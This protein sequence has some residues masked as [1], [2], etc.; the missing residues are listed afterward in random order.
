MII[1]LVIFILIVISIVI[2]ID[3]KSKEKEKELGLKK[4][5]DLKQAI[6]QE[7]TFKRSDNKPISD[8][9][10]PGLIKLGYQQALEREKQS[11]NIKFHRTERDEELSFQ[12]ESNH[13]DEIDKHVKSFE[14]CYNL[15]C[16][17][18]DLN[19][20]IELLQKTII[21]FE[22]AK[23]WFYKTRGGTVYFQ[24]M[25]EHLHNS[26]N[27]DFSYIS[28]VE[29]DLEECIETKKC[30]VD[31]ILDLIKSSSEG[32]LQKDIYDSVPKEAA[33]GI[34]R[35]LERNGTIEKTKSGSSYLITIKETQQ[36]KEEVN[37]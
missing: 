34:I 5:A 4:E 14:E 23:N 37:V 2:N 13:W 16:D 30:M 21:K 28:Q 26:R 22:K 1:F 3:T 18:D 36:K 12:F 6:E 10:I 32:I 27:N 19:K 31:E 29:E 33:Q 15:A 9:E 24:D 7:R 8:E 35:E 20:K 25:Y 11:K 17:E